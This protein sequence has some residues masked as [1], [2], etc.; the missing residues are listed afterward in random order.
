MRLAH[1]GTEKRDDGWWAVLVVDGRII[2]SASQGPFE[3][4]DDAAE[5]AAMIAKMIDDRAVKP[6]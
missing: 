4:E 2:E 5:E 3:D 1:A 6:S